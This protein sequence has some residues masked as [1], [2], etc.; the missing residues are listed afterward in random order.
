MDYAPPRHGFRTFVIVWAAESLSVIGNGMTSFALN[1]YLTQVLY[2]APDQ[3][4]EL[5][6]ARPERRVGEPRAQHVRAL[7][8]VHRRLD[9]EAGV[10]SP[11]PYR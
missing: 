5:A 10:K 1:V 4:T 9:V 2:P 7:P 6:I 11:L 8:E 3:R